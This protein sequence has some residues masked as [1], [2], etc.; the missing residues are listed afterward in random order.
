MVKEHRGCRRVVG[1]GV[2]VLVATRNC[3]GSM[4]LAFAVELSV[5]VAVAL[6]VTSAVALV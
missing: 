5:V 1:G 4:A 3:G 2:I 6:V